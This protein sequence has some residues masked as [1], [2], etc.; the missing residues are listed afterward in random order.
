ME[1]K[2]D[3]QEI[4]M[5]SIIDLYGGLFKV[6]NT[7]IRASDIA[8]SEVSIQVLCAFLDEIKNDNNYYTEP[9]AKLSTNQEL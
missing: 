9:L 5:N 7:A 2:L 6:L 8:D 1:S 3:P 4:I